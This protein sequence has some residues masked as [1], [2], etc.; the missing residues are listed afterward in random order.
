MEFAWR[1]FK[2]LI[3]LSMRWYVFEISAQR[4]LLSIFKNKTL[5]FLAWNVASI[6]K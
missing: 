4:M 1:D 5:A 2:E 3:K 6:C